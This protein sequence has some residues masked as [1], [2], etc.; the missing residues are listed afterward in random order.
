MLFRSYKQV[1]K[2]IQNHDELVMCFVALEGDPEE[3]NRPVGTQE[4][5]PPE[6]EPIEGSQEPEASASR[7]QEPEFIADTLSVHTFR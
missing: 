5:N 3:P 2:I 1:P 6:N 4:Q 7:E